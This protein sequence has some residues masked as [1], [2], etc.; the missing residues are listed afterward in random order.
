MPEYLSP[1]DGLGWLDA[2][3]DYAAPDSARRSAQ[4]LRMRMLVLPTWDKHFAQVQ[5]LL[6]QI[7]KSGR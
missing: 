4:L 7:E 2:I 5:I 3:A 6:D 1:L